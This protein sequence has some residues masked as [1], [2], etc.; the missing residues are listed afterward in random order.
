MPFFSILL[1]T[2][3]RS[4][5]VGYAIR[6][7]IQQDFEDFEIIICDNDDDAN[8]TRLVI[9]SFDDRRLKYVRTGGLDMVSNW[10]CALNI[11]SGENIT[12]LEDKMIF[13]PGALSDIKGK[14]EESP[15]G[16]VVWHSD[17]FDDSHMPSKL[18][19]Y[20]PSGQETVTSRAILDLVTTDVLRYW[21]RLPRGLSCSVP[22]SVVTEV[23]KHHGRD[24]FEPM[25]PDFVSA[26]KVLGQVDEILAIYKAYTLVGSVRGSTGNNAL[27]GKE[28]ALKYYSGQKTV[29]LSDEFVAVKNPMIVVNCIINDYRLLAAKTGGAIKGCRIEHKDYVKMMARDLLV[30][31]FI[32]KK[33]VW[34]K[35]NLLQLVRSEGRE[36]RNIFY[37]FTYIMNFLASHLLKK[38]GIGV[39][40]QK[41]NVTYIDEGPLERLDEF[42]SGKTNLGG[43]ESFPVSGDHDD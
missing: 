3:N 29:H 27:A 13:Y 17:I 40:N 33:L 38:I 24:Y 35:K 41:T 21:G 43:V 14:I 2:K 9:E 30:S 26:L 37:I 28:A 31:T 10:N 16:V 34:D 11:A 12:V 8:A 25:S 19:Q 39:E 42:L 18:V 23:K 5:L 7:V 32:A 15:S 36:I 20:P 6:S 22:G 4:Q 1:P